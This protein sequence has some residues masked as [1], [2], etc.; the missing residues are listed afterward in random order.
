MNGHLSESGIGNRPFGAIRLDERQGRPRRLLHHFPKG[1]G[2][3][4]VPFS[5]HPR[6]LYE[7]NIATGFGPGKTG[8]HANPVLLGRHL[9]EK[10]T[11]TEELLDQL[12]RD[13]CAVMSL[14]W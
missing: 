1:S 5:L 11:G 4:Q 13:P 10:L 3:D 2:Q 6:G 7:N 14:L 8:Y 12:G 9:V